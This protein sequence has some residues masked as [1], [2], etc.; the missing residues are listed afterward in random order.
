MRCVLVMALNCIRGVRAGALGNVENLF[1]A[2][3]PRST[4]TLNDSNCSGQ[5][6]L[7]SRI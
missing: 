7:V 2:I 3:T 5:I 6:E 4:L 1:I